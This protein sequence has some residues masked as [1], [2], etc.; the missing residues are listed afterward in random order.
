MRKLLVVSLVS[1]WSIVALA[2]ADTLIV[3]GG[4]NSYKP[5]AAA[6]W[7]TTADS[8][9]FVLADGVDGAKVA[10]TLKERLATAKV[11]LDGKKLTVSGVPSATLLDQ[12]S[13]LS[14]SGEADPLAALAGLGGGQPANEAPEGGGSIR[15]ST[16][17]NVGGMI[18]PQTAE[19]QASATEPSA[20]N[21]VEAEVVDV[22]RGAFPQVSLKLKVKKNAKAGP[23]KEK[24]DKGDTFSGA[25]MVSTNLT[26]PKNQRNLG[27]YYLKKGDKVSVHAQ[28]K[29]DAYEVDWVERK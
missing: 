12:L 27:A 20:D 13:G 7:T 11:A 19:P 16:P 15:A 25:V 14:L 1:M 28:P 22:S 29:G 9:T 18:G 4:N 26:D 2:A 10:Q 23:L 6:S 24:L 21:M 8:V 5:G 3:S 17:R